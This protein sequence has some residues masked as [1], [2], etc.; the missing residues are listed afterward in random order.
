MTTTT[1]T[2]RS[3]RRRHRSPTG[4]R[5]QSRVAIYILL[6][7]AAVV[8]IFPIW[9]IIATSLETSKRAYSF[10]GALLPQG[11]LSNFTAAWA[12]APWARLL[13][14]SLLVAGATT[15]GTLILGFMAAYSLVYL[16]KGSLRRVLFGGIVATMMVPFYA[17]LIPDYIIVRDMGLLNG[18]IAQILPFVGGGFAIFLLRQFIGAFPYELRDAAT[19]DG[20]GEWGFMWR[21]LLPNMRPAL[22]TVGV[23]TFIL[24]WNAFL[25]PLIVTTSPSVQPVQVGMAEV[26]TTAN[27]TDFT[28]LSAAAAIT[29]LPIVLVYIFAQRHVTDSIHRS[30]LKG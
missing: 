15:L 5:W 14:N 17:V 23:Y 6:V 12:Q 2:I 20:L 22:A 27:G 18:Y 28:M 13:A 26:L 16:F 10:P 30:G 25:W 24:S 7:V 29:A 9:W 3:P 8:A 1:A 19:T 11:V 4:L 21:I